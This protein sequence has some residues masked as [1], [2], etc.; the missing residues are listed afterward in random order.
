MYK[1]QPINV[2]LPLKSISTSLV[3]DFFKERER[4]MIKATFRITE[5]SVKSETIY[6]LFLPI[7]DL[8]IA[9]GLLTSKMPNV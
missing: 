1:R 3:E 6:F 9:T 2:Y 8:H 7:L 5:I 4:K